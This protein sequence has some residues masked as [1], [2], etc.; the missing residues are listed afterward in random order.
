V[1]ALSLLIHYDCVH[2]TDCN[3]Q[4][5]LTDARCA[6]YIVCVWLPEPNT[7]AAA[8]ANAVRW[9]AISHHMNAFHL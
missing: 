5:Q 6:T 4:C 3:H 2:T 7:P 8:A 9:C 1:T